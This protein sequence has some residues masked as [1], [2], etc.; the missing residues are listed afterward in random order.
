MNG[1][2]SH[3]TPSLSL[4]DNAQCEQIHHASLEILRRTGVRVHHEEAVALLR[5]AGCPVEDNNL[6][7]FPPFLV[8]WALGQAPPVIALC[9]RGTDF[10]SVPLKPGVTTFGPGSD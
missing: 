1:Y 7:R 9:S 3:A 8:E 10:A 6:V 2:T 5:D 4:M